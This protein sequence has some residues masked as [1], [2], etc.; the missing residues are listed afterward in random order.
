M[1]RRVVVTGSASGIGRSV[2]ELLRQQGDTVIGVDRADAEVRADLSEASGRRQAVSDVLRRCDGVLDAL[3]ACAGLS[4]PDPETVSVNYFG[5][6]ELAVALRPALAAAPQPRVGVVASISGTQPFDTGI[7]TSCL[8]GAE[9]EARDRATTLVSGGNGRQ[10][11]PSAKVA[12]T[13]WVRRVCVSGGWADA[14][15]AVNAVAP[16]VVR[17][18]M[19]EPLLRDE[20]MRAAAAKAV[21]MPLHGTAS[22]AAIARPLCW[23][24]D[25]ATTH[26]TGQ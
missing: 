16:G 15:I 12:V 26:I 3:V 11:Y 22:A 8:N 7:V 25:P 4:Q 19:T 20:T 13:R 6:V 21:P 10:V 5:T 2:V 18:P 24:V 14:G 1:A 23:L 9:D 17:T